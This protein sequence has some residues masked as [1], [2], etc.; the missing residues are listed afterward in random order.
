LPNPPFQL[1]ILG[2]TEVIGP[3]SKSGEAV[4]RQP[5]RLALLAYLALST[6]D[7]FR[8]RD[9][10]IGLF[11]PELDQTQA[12][13]NLRKALYAIREAFGEEIF[14]TRGEDEIRLD[15]AR[16]WCDAVALNAH[17][18]DGAW[19]EALTL[20]RG[21]LLEGLYPDGVAQEFEE[22]LREQ[23]NV[24]RSRAAQAAWECSRL[25][26]ERGDRAAASAMAR[27]A[28]E[29]DPDNEEGVRR[30]MELLDRRGDRG[31]ALRV[32]SEWRD[33]LQAEFG[34]DPAPETRKV[35]RRVQAARK[36]ESH[37]TPPA[38]AATLTASAAHDSNASAVID[39]PPGASRSTPK[40]ERATRRW[41]IPLSI[42][43]AL[44]LAL[45]IVAG[46]AWVDKSN[47]VPVDS[48]SVAVLP[49]RP[50]GD[51]QLQTIAA[52]MSEALTKALG[53]DTSLDVRS[54]AFLVD[55][56]VQRGGSQLRVTLR[57]I[58]G[59]EG[60]ALW[61][62][63]YDVSEPWSSASAGRIA[64]EA[65]ATIRERIDVNSRSR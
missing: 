35:A 20:Y 14:S 26:E 5:K 44:G 28:R 40:G 46:R 47:T 16:V 11:W 48:S 65:A 57:L 18:R 27:R 62:G 58:R 17:V 38:M 49:L 1:R 10:I 6:A 19:S 52:G 24:L 33:R 36:G 51:A 8:R 55:G 31:G 42:G 63:S 13:T 61:T 53:V 64:A 12:R 59:A 21:D 54:R 23:R 43:L 29:F 50:I 9:S 15:P 34:V 41:V 30:L 3:S 56:V 37:E 60:V 45:G 7:G 25:A 32:Y 22:W 4:V 39:N 2:P